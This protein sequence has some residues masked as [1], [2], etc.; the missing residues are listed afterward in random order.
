VVRDGETELAR[1]EGLPRELERVVQ[2]FT[3]EDIYE[4]PK[5]TLECCVALH[6]VITVENSKS[7]DSFMRCSTLNL[8]E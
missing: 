7:H 5:E 3:Q 6:A 8:E 2:E 1:F 4:H